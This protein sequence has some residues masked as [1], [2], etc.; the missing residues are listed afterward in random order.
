[1][2]FL[3]LSDFTWIWRNRSAD[4]IRTL[5]PEGS[6]WEGNH[7]ERCAFRNPAVVDAG[8]QDLFRALESATG[9]RLVK[10]KSVPID[11]IVVNRADKVPAE[12]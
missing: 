2:G 5:R 4:Q 3:R 7:R 8:G 12:N 9:L 11:V 1:M 10:A 6:D